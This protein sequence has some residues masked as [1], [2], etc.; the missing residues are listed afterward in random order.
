[1]FN[2]TDRK[3]DTALQPQ[4]CRCRQTDP[5]TDTQTG[6]DTLALPTQMQCRLH[7][8][9]MRSILD[10]KLMLTADLQLCRVV[11][12]HLCILYFKG[13][14]RGGCEAAS[15]SHLASLLCIEAG[16]FQDQPHRAVTALSRVHKAAAAQNG[17]HFCLQHKHVSAGNQGFVHR[18]RR[19]DIFNHLK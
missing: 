18:K 11:K 17:L 8:C 16:A 3:A 13:P 10:H 1:M 14:S 7:V 5:Q 15:V 9:D 19:E 6:R 12:P 4:M 2:P